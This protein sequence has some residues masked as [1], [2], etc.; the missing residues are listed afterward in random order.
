MLGDFAV[1]SFRPKQYHELAPEVGIEPTTSRLTGGCSTAELLGINSV[2]LLHSSLYSV[3]HQ[4]FT[5]STACRVYL[6]V[7]FLCSYCAVENRVICFLSIIGRSLREKVKFSKSVGIFIPYILIL[8]WF[9]VFVNQKSSVWGNK[10]VTVMSLARRGLFLISSYYQSI[11][12]LI[13][14]RQQNKK[15]GIFCPELLRSRYEYSTSKQLEPSTREIGPTCYIILGDCR[16]H[17][18]LLCFHVHL[19]IIKFNSLE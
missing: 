1:S 9:G 18:S 16:K 10:F 17:F 13:K 7:T 11:L 19:F 15:L 8:N 2:F 6:P 5:G 14:C 3:P 12:I 4:V